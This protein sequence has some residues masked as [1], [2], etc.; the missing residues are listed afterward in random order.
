MAPP[1]AAP[2]LR[3]LELT[4]DYRC[5]QRCVGCGAVSEGG[6]SLSAGAMVSSMRDARRDGAAQLWIGGG[7]PTLRRDLLPLVREARAQ[8]FARIRLQTNAA[9]LAYPEVARR[10]AEAGVTELAVSIKGPDAATHDRMA[11]SEGAFDLLCRGIESARSHGLAVEGDVLAYRSTTS[12]L[13]EIVR[14][15]AARGITRFRVWMMAPSEGDAEALA[16][17]PRWSEVARAVRET[18]A[19]SLSDEP[20]HLLSLHTPPCTLDDDAAR[21]RFFAPELGLLVHDASG[22]RFPLESS[23]IEGGAFPPACDGCE[24]RPRCNGVRA[25]YV[26]RHGDAEL[27]PRR[28]VG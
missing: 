22:R 25:A 10:L 1:I 6:P 19:L 7:E 15:F 26:V 12:L 11:R 23:D 28:P 16:E 8:G 14:T 13:P 2:G 20:D 3:W 24:L 17:E 21:A 5:N 9:M 27:R 4:P 18:L